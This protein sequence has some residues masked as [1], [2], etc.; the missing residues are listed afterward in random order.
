MLKC[1][2]HEAAMKLTCTGNFETISAETV[3]LL[4]KL[5]RVFNETDTEIA[6]LFRRL[7]TDQCNDPDSPLWMTEVPND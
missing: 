2:I 7:I 4:N 1:E 5:Y 6:K 3:L